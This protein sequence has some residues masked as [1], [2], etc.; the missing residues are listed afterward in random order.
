MKKSHLVTSLVLLMLGLPCF[1]QANKQEKSQKSPDVTP[2][3][4]VG[5]ISIKSKAKGTRCLPLVS[6]PPVGDPPP[7]G[8]VVACPYPQ[9]FSSCHGAGSWGCGSVNG[10]RACWT[11]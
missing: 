8:I 1:A 11:N 3:C 5:Q 6:V 2:A 7:Q 4:S 10:I 9:K